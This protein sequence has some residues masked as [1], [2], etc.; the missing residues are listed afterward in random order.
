ML[1]FCARFLWEVQKLL[2]LLENKRHL[3]DAWVVLLVRPVMAAPRRLRVHR[4]LG[5]TPWLDRRL[6]CP[7]QLG[8]PVLV[9]VVYQRHVLL[10]ALLR[11]EC[12]RALL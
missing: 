11:L 9:L 8:I 10:E 6:A 4:R 2:V 1:Q 7:V 12:Q 3:V 5:L